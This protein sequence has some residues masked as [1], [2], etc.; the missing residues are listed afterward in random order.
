MKWEE[1]HGHGV[2]MFLNNVQLQYSSI[3]SFLFNLGS[4]SGL[5]MFT[6]FSNT[7][8]FLSLNLPLSIFFTY[9]KFNYS[10]G[11]WRWHI[12]KLVSNQRCCDSKIG[13]WGQEAHACMNFLCFYTSRCIPLCRQAVLFI[14][15]S[16][17]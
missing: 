9:M 8:H 4:K 12:T 3:S 6:D 5:G 2:S 16:S 1:T 17:S 7:K 15:P 13:S 10:S 14:T 11:S